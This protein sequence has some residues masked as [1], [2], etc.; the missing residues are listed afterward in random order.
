M[1]PRLPALSQPARS[2]ARTTSDLGGP[3]GTRRPFALAALIALL[4]AVLL[5][6]TWGAS[7]A[8]LE[9]VAGGAAWLQ[10]RNDVAARAALS[11]VLVATAALAFV[12]AWSRTS[13]PRRPVRVP[14]GRGTIAVDEVAAWMRDA[15]RE[16]TD[17]RDVA[18]TVQSQG[19][20]VRVAARIAVTADARL[21]E[22]SRGARAA[23]EQVL[24][25]QVGVPLVA[26][27][28]IELRY[29]PFCTRNPSFSRSPVTYDAV[30]N[31]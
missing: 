29:A 27:P 16:R 3:V 14:G 22:T 10:E 24:A 23:I 5:A 25:A 31:S 7:N 19:K 21:Q 18:I 13:D 26:E 17:I 9:G 11:V 15:V 1:T 20:G 8:A 30:S 6:V 4:A 28:V 12:V 2:H